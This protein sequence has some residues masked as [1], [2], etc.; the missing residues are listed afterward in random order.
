MKNLEV[1]LMLTE[2]TFHTGTV[3]LNYA[4]S[5]R[6][7][8][9]LVLLHGGSARW[10]A[11]EPL[12]GP[13]VAHHHLYAL[14]LRGHGRSGHVPGGYRIQDY[15]GDLAAFLQGCVA[16]PA[17]LVGHSL[18]GIVAVMAAGQR[19]ELIAGLVVVDAPLSGK[20]WDEALR[21]SLDRVVAWRDLAAARLPF[22]QVIERLKE[23]PVELPGEAAPVPA[24]QALGEDSG[25]FTWMATNMSQFDPGHLTILI[26]D[27]PRAAAGYEMEHLL[28]QITAPVL[29]LQ[30]DPACGAAL[31]DAEVAQAL[32]LLP[33]ATHLQLAGADH[34]LHAPVHQGRLLAAV[35][36][37]L[38]SL[39]G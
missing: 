22:E 3:T 38:A 23:T 8:L 28:P 17:V 24:R 9:P 11:W 21:P 26:E 15:A 39:S 6:A 12:I 29:L 4:E 18:G 25:W 10:Q 2:R 20:S 27:L 14:D 37:F 16:E 30:A 35:L 31:S 33:R 1:T 32:A 36:P 19:P 13:L 5:P 7:G 34:A